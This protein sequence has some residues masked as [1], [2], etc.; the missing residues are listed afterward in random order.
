MNALE[1]L[2]ARFARIATIGEATAILNWDAAA[3]MPSGGAAA[4]GDQLAVLAGLAHELLIAPEIGNDLTAAETKPPED[5]WEAVNL[6]L[7]RHAYTRATALPTDLVEARARACSAC[8]QVWRKAREQADFDMVRPYLETVVGLERQAAQAL[9]EALGL[10]PYDALMDG[11]QRGI[12][13]KQVA[14]VFA[15]Y[16]AF[17]QR[18]LPEAEARQGRLPEPGHSRST[19]RRSFAVAWPNGSAWTSLTRGW[20]GRRILS[21]AAAPPMYASPAAT[22]KLILLRRCLRS[23]MKPATRS[24]NA[25]CPGPGHASLSARTLA[26]RRMKASP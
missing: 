18:A 9:G 11:H 2:T 12:R 1:R 25:A 3:M 7:M 10:T 14:P 5:E 13:G 24:T 6:A 20:I 8:E 21:R 26:W 19:S 16:E 17:V 15:D 22:P 23:F 4:R